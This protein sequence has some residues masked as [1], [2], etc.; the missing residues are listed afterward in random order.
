MPTAVIVDAV[1]TAAG[2][3][4]GRLKEWHPVDLAAETLKALVDRNGIDPALVDDVIMGCVIQV[5]EQGL[6]IARNAV[7][8]AGWPESVPGTTRRPPVRLVAAVGP[9]RRPGRDRRRLRHRGGRRC[10]GHDPSAD[11]RVDRRRQVRRP[12]RP[13]DGGARYADAGRPGAAGHLG[14]A[15]RREVGAVTGGAR[16]VRAALTAVRGAGPRRGPLRE[17]DPAGT[18]RRGRADHHRRGHPRVVAGEAGQPQAVVQGGRQGDGG[19][20]LAD[21]RRCGRAAHHERGEGGRPRSAAP[22]PVRAVRPRRRRP[23]S[24]C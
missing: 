16:R 17:R 20:Q 12:V 4:N 7:L 9:L 21:H 18:R 8:A 3:R 11:G 15:D 2:K 19:Q 5:G 13:P 1:R 23:A 10:R 22:G 6:N 24:R 14:R